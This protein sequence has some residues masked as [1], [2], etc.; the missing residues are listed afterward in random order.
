MAGNSHERGQSVAGRLLRVLEAFSP[1]RPDLTISEISRRTGIP[2]STLYR[3]LAELVGRGA[4]ER[5][6]DGKYSVGLRLWEIGKLAPLPTRLAEVASP[7]LQDLFEITRG[8]IELALLARGEALYV[9][10][11]C[12][13]HPLD[14]PARAGMRVPLTSTSIGQ[15]LLAY[16]PPD[17]LEQ[18][19]TKKARPT[20][21][22]PTLPTQRLRAVLA[23]IR[24]CGVAISRPH[25][26]SLAVAA[27]V[28]GPSSEVV[29]A[30]ALTVPDMAESRL[31]V[32]IV[33]TMAQRISR[34]LLGSTA[35][36]AISHGGAP[37][38][39]PIPLGGGP[40]RWDRAART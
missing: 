35:P 16:A 40:A 36:G 27:P 39:A 9:Q 14:R 20:A 23:D 18:I 5:S 26:G 30:L 38:L 24:R 3:L 33:R 21:A 34:E 12:G 25:G 4:V 19:L 2:S 6:A 15:I 13:H 7:Y 32:P 11:I 8:G 10:T 28:F 22:D 17:A 29:A 1:Q 31:V 37:T